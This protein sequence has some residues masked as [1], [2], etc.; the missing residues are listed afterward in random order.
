VSMFASN[1]RSQKC[2]CSLQPCDL[3]CGSRCATEHD[4]LLPGRSITR[5]WTTPFTLSQEIRISPACVSQVNYINAHATSTIVGDLAEVNA[6][7]K[8]FAK[9]DHMK[10]NGTKVRLRGN[11]KQSSVPAIAESLEV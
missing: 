1:L 3:R 6:V 5:H 11:R 4:F 10:M 2:P 9:A 8:C 7:K